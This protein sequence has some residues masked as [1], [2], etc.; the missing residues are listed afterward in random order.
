MSSKNFPNPNKQKNEDGKLN[1]NEYKIGPIKVVKR[2][3]K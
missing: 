3:H 1:G 2:F